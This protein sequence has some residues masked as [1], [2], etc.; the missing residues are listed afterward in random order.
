MIIDKNAV[1]PLLYRLRDGQLAASSKANQIY[2][3]TV[4]WFSG[5]L[6]NAKL[7]SERIG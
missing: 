7:V 2:Q 5:F 4:H 1:T 3:C 6:S